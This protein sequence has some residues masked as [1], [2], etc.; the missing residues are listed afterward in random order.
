MQGLA[1]TDE[2]TLCGRFNPPVQVR[3]KMVQCSAYDDKR[4]PSRWDME[5]IAWVLV[6]N[7]AGKAIGFVS[8]EEA[9]RSSVPSPPTTQVGF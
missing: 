6:T 8:A 2:R 3:G 9:R 5:Q 7:K 1:V 4:V